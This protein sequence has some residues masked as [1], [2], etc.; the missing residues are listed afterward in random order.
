MI[1]KLQYIVIE[2]VI[3]VGKTTLTG[4]LANRLNAKMVLEQPEEN[5]FLEDFYKRPKQY[6]FQT[7]LFFLLSRYRQQQAIPQRDL[8]HQTIVA[9]YLFAK[10]KIFAYLNLED[11]ELRLYE[12]IVHLLEKD[13]TRCDLVVYLKS[14]PS[15]LMENITLRDRPY[16]R[17]MEPGYIEAL[18]EAYNKFF[19]HYHDSPLLVVDTTR[20]DFVKRKD[21]FEYLVSRIQNFN[22]QEQDPTS[23]AFLD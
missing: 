11:R 15:R 18:N 9:D 5:P 2:G 1:L 17:E 23:W 10:D 20:L 8:F 13:I 22:F 16:E 6:A 21:D 19:A 14:K 3:G 7:Q 4:M 12:K